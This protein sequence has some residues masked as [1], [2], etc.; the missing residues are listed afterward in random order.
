MAVRVLATLTTQPGKGGDLLA[1]WPDLSAQVR[2]EEPNL[3][4]A[5]WRDTAAPDVF[6]VWE[7]WESMD[8]LTAHGRSPHMREFGAAAAGFLAGRAVVQ[9][10]GEVG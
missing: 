3:E 5:L 10:L 6:V 1:R 4:Y 7:L 2:A 8:G 9:V